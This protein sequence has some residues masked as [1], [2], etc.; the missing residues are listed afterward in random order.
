MISLSE[1]LEGIWAERSAKMPLSEPPFVEG[2][3]CPTAHL[4]GSLA[5]FFHPLLRRLGLNGHVFLTPF[6]KLCVDFGLLFCRALMR[7]SDLRFGLLPLF[8]PALGF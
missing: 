6:S 3:L 7:I 8:P 1:L 5:V 2:N 4:F